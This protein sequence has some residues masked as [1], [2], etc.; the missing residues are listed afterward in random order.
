MKNVVWYCLSAI[1]TYFIMGLFRGDFRWLEWD[2]TL[3]VWGGL[4]GVAIASYRARKSNNT[5]R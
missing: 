2:D 3:P 4:I 1:V 5:P